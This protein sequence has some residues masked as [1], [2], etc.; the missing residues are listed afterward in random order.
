MDMIVKCR[1]QQ[2]CPLQGE[3][4]LSNGGEVLGRGALAGWAGQ[5]APA[6]D[7][8]GNWHEEVNGL[9]AWLLLEISWGWH[10]GD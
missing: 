1:D 10:T 4:S 2:K 5:Q 9:D 8:E 3:S 7:R 6:M